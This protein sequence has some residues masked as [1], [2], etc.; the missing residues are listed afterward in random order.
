MSGFEIAGVVLG[1]FPILTDALK[2]ARG[3]YQKVKRWWNFSIAFEDFLLR[4]DTER[5]AFLQNL[6]NLLTSASIPEPDKQLLMLD[7]R[8]DLWYSPSIQAALRARISDP[9]FDW[10][11]TV[12]SDIREALDE[13]KEFLPVG[14]MHQI[15]AKG[16]HDIIFRAKTSFS[17]RKD[18]LL[19]RIQDRNE[20]IFKF[21]L[22]ESIKPSETPKPTKSTAN[23]HQFIRAQKRSKELHQVL[24]SV[25]KCQC[26]AS[27]SCGIS[28]S[29][30]S[31]KLSPIEISLLVTDS[32]KNHLIRVEQFEEEDGCHQGSSVASSSVVEDISTV[33]RQLA[34]KNKSKGVE[35]SKGALMMLGKSAL[36][37]TLNPAGSTS[38]STTTIAQATVQGITLS[39]AKPLPKPRVRFATSAAQTSQA[40]L[41]QKNAAALTNFCASLSSA[42]SKTSSTLLGFLQLNREEKVFLRLNTSRQFPCQPDA[43]TLAGF[44]SSTPRRGTRVQV[45]LDIAISLL[46]L[47]ST[48]WISTDL[49]KT[50]IRV[51]KESLDPVQASCVPTPYL[52]RPEP[53]SSNDN[54]PTR[55]G[56]QQRL[57]AL[58]ILLLELLFGQNV[59]QHPDRNKFMGPDGKPN[60]YTDMCTA[61]EWQK[62]V[63]LEVGDGL[64]GAI[65][66]CLSC[67]FGVDRDLGSPQ[68]IQAVLSY[69]VEPLRT[70]LLSWNTTVVIK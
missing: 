55:D 13:I 7:P 41:A 70:F 24:R 16:A 60:R 40:P 6:D 49:N 34:Y 56:T 39:S 66:K 29:M 69:V 9:Y 11:I 18:H 52:F 33:R 3:P 62:Q 8:C 10:Y 28:S 30:S 50:H 44:L 15:D 63:E 27:H 31:H 22:R 65:Q 51:V 14:K 5:V 37:S 68:F 61:M 67:D 20:E 54:I 23:S 46:S 45:G 47:D 1:A 26:T 64:S 21:L 25:W 42:T 19:D 43:E 53:R 32:S 2:D 58:G 35:T 4:L 57:L 38:S 48:T 17:S 59:E 12:L 36:S